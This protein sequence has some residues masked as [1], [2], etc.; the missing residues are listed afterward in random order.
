MTK[1]ETVIGIA[2]ATVTKST[3]IFMSSGT[4]YAFGK[5]YKYT[6]IPN[7]LDY[8]L[9]S[10]GLRF[11]EGDTVTMIFNL[12]KQSLEFK[13]ND[14]NKACVTINDIKVENTVRYKMAVYLGE[15]ED[16]IELLSYKNY[17]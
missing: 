8:D 14:Q 11:K 13:I 7:E 1:K 9:N 4:G 16:W 15:P 10:V 2:E 6:P 12:Y 5:K 17:N 3:G